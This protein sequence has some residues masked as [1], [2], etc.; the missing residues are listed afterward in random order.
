MTKIMTDINK[1]RHT[2]TGILTKIYNIFIS[3]NEEPYGSFQSY[4]NTILK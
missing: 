4:S 1:V 2:D 3:L